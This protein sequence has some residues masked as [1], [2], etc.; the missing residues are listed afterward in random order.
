MTPKGVPWCPVTLLRRLTLDP[1]IVA[2]QVSEVRLRNPRGR[3][4]STQILILSASRANGEKE[5][6]NFNLALFDFRRGPGVPESTVMFGDLPLQ[7]L[8]TL[9]E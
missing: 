6:C 1:P 7:P 4:L 8:R 5:H 9:P 3:V 2:E